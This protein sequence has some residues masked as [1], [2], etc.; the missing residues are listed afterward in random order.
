M[1]ISKPNAQKGLTLSGLI[2]SAFVL[3]L[4]LTTGMKLVPAYI[5]NAKIQKIFNDVSNDPNMQKASVG[6]IRMSY[7]RRA[8]IDDITSITMN[9]VDVDKSSGKPILSASYSKKIPL[10]GNIS[11]Y[12]EFNPVSGSK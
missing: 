8:S 1:Y 7:I 3:V 6:D 4:V 9:D 12:L 10:A 11:F 5:E 2:G